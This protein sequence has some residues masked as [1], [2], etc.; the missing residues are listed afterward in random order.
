MENSLLLYKDK[1]L[2]ERH[3]PLS[4]ALIKEAHDQ[5]SLAYPGIDKT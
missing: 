4:T 2:I 1:L 3:T 5:I